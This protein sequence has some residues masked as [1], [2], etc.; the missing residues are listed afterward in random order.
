[1][2]PDF[3][4]TI[5]TEGDNLWA[6]PRVV[7]TRN[8]AFLP[9]FQ[10][11]AERFGLRPTW[12][13][14]WEMAREP[15]CVDYLREVLA[16]GVGE[17]GL[18]LH[19]WDT[20]PL[21]P[22]T[23]DDTRHH[24]FLTEYP[25][26]LMRAKIERLSAVLEDTFQRPVRSHRAGRWA[27]DGRYARLLRERGFATDCSVCPGVSWR[28]T[29]GDPRGRGGPDYR[30]APT[31][32]YFVDEHD[33]TRP[34]P[35]S[36]RG[37]LLEVP[38]TIGATRRRWPRSLLASRR[39][40]W[41]RPNGRNGAALRQ[42]VDEAVAAGHPHLL[43]MLH[44]SELMPGGSPTFRDEKSIARL[45]EDLEQLFAHARARGCAGRTLDE[46]STAWRAA[47]GG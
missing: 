20:P 38:M 40:S 24:P 5:D 4:I 30:A 2:P 46:F 17:V 34:A 3:L 18:H 6:R 9:R 47:H 8:A 21:E 23:K 44:S 11:L 16:R 13:V 32:P 42:R 35:A 14:N 22:L 28:S 41:L 12:L 33:V 37:A 36:T 27:F 39:D 29:K 25:E 26:A 19:A 31:T 7:T 10:Q 1:M 45:Y 43:F 15:V